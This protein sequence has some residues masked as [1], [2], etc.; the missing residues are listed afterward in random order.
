MEAR[1]K[2]EERIKEIEEELARTQRNKATEFHIGLLNA[3][4]AKLGRDL[5]APKK[6]GKGGGFGV[7]KS[8]DRTVAI[9][10]PPSVGKS[11]LLNAIS[12]SSSKTGAYAFTTTTAIPGMLSYNG[13]LIQLVDLPGVIEGTKGGKKAVLSIARSA[14]LIIIMLDVFNLDKQKAIREEL[15]SIGMRLDEKPPNVSI[16][17]KEK[18]GLF[19]S[20]TAKLTKISEKMIRGI[21]NEYGI[22]NGTVSI[23]EDIT[24]EQLIDVVV[25]NRMYLPSITLINKIDLV[26]KSYLSQLPRDYVTV[27]VQNKI[28]LEQL[29]EKIYSS[30]EI[31]RVYTKPRVSDEVDMSKPLV[32]KK[33]STV[34]DICKLLP[35]TVQSEFKCAVVWG[36]SALYQGQKVGPTHILQDGDVVTIQKG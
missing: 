1:E 33:G 19:I 35:Q 26:N 20:S 17:K 18:G 36:K 13:A 30:L 3:K 31:M 32:V 14:D 5:A 23:R 25:G 27:S 12:N 16:T 21:F 7:R 15:A 24:P 8:G 4:L 28:G 11:S 9:V 22:H 29:K 2:I 6:K 10:G 34:E